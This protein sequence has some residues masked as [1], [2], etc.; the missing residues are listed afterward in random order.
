MSLAHAWIRTLLGITPAPAA[1]SP[2]FSCREPASGS[3]GVRGRGRLPLDRRTRNA[4]AAV[5][6][7]SELLGHAEVDEAA[8]EREE[9]QRR[10]LR[11]LLS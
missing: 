4:V 8:E 9:E 2:L 6:R 11:G 7:Q 5:L 10:Q 1:C 3:G